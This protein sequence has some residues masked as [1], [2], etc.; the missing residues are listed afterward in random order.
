MCNNGRGEPWFWG[1]PM[2]GKGRLCRVWAGGEGGQRGGPCRCPGARCGCSARAAAGSS[3]PSAALYPRGQGGPELKAP[4]PILMCSRAL[5]TFTP[6][7]QQPSEAQVGQS[8]QAT[9]LV[10][11]ACTLL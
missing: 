3:L 5:P 6:L 4:S 11:A 10:Y 8:P 7:A 9:D 1:Q 2:E